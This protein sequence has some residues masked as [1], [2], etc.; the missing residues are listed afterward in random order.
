MER[1]EVNKTKYLAV[2][3]LTTL[4]FLSGLI[5]GNYISE[6][7]LS[8]LDQMQQDIRTQT[9]A[10]E[11]EYALLSENP[12]SST[13]HTALNQELYTLST[14]LNYMENSLGPNNEDVLQLKE[15]YSLLE[16]RHWLL[17]K[18][19]NAECKQNKKL[20]LYFYSNAGDCER[21]EEQGYLLSYFH[22]KYPELL[23][24]SF[25]INLNNIALRTL[26]SQLEVTSAPTVI[27]NE[28]KI[29]GFA[30]KLTLEKQFHLLPNT[31]VTS[32]EQLLS[33]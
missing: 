3:A 24:Y 8:K 7:K 33:N 4:I 21:C 23:I 1:R 9:T 28:N 13:N 15:Y 12:C 17:F 5:V 19:V 14:R 26:K 29:E 6:K 30:D 32:S 16:L 22:K 10:L 18:K 27:V 25:D 2:F 31:N 11:V 20:I